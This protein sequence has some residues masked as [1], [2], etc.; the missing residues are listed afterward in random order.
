MVVQLVHKLR[1]GLRLHDE[2]QIKWETA[3]RPCLPVGLFR[4][5]S[6]SARMQHRSGSSVNIYKKFALEFGVGKYH[7]GSVQGV[8]V[9]V[10][11]CRARI[12]NLA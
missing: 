11:G 5:S 3:P 4:R 6:E 12:E 2:V 7:L 8:V 10:P 9:S 1:D